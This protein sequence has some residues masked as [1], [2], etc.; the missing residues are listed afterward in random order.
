[1]PAYW[2]WALNTAVLHAKANEERVKDKSKLA[3]FLFLTDTHWEQNNRK[4]FRVA[5]YLQ[6]ELGLESLIFGGDA[7]DGNASLSVAAATMADWLQAINTFNGTWYAVRG[8]HDQNASW[9]PTSLDEVWTDE[10][11][12]DHVLQ[13]AGNARTDGSKK[14][15]N[16]VDDPVAKIRYYFLA[17]DSGGYTAG[18]IDTCLKEGV[19][20]VPYAEQ[21]AWLQ[22][23]AATL[24]EGWGIVVTEHAMFGS[25]DQSGNPTANRFY[26]ILIPA[27]NEIDRQNEVIAVFSGH[28]HW[29]GHLLT[30]G[31]YYVISSTND[32]GAPDPS[33]PLTAGTKDEQRMEIVQID[34][35]SRKLY[36]TRIGGGY[37]RTFTY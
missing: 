14:L 26:E 2:T 6:A 19:N 12:Y 5:N 30:E 31:G 9:L 3:S 24:E 32:G 17:D 4:T 21:V 27:L 20:A 8:N 25:P 37:N 34:R 36:L 1:V 15:Y 13:Y 7:I 29:D 18:G 28:T 11:Y 33:Y 22:E 16:Y 10:E 23:T 35:E